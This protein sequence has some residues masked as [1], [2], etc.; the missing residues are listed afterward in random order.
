M[1]TLIA[2][3]LL[4]GFFISTADAQVVQTKS[5]Q[6]EGV[7]LESGIHL[8][9]GIPFAAPPVGDLRWRPP[10]PVAPWDGVRPAKEWG[11][12][13]MQ[14]N[15]FGDMMS[16]SESI[17]E[18]CLYLNVWTPNPSPDAKLPVLVY[19][20]GGGFIAGDGAE[21]RYAGESMAKQGIVA[22]TFNYRLGVFGFFAH[23]ELSAESPHGASGN[24][25]YLD[26][27]AALQWVRDNI[28]AF[29]G[30]PNRITIAGESAG[31]ISVS[32]HM[33][34]PLSKHL[35]QGAIGES[36]SILGALPPVPLE[37]AEQNGVRFASDVGATTLEALRA[38]PADKLL[39]LAAGRGIMGF[40]ST[41]DGYFFEEPPVK[42]FAEGRQAKV[43]L[44]LGWNSE[45]MNAMMVL[46]PNPPTPENWEA[47][48]QRLYGEHAPR[49]LELYKASTEDE[50]LQAATD[51]AGDRFISFS[52]WKWF[53]L[54]RKTGNAPVYRYY[55]TR[56]RPPMRPEVGNATPG[57][58]GG[59]QR[60]EDA[61]AFR[62]P[63]ARGAVHS[64]EIEYAM[65][66][67]ATNPV[68]AW[69]EDDYKVS[70]TMLG[71]FANFVKTGNPNGPGL[72][73]WPA[74]SRDPGARSQIM[75]IDVTS[76][77]E[78]EPYPDRYEF[79]DQLAE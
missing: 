14:T 38:L 23:P 4:M 30:D 20:Y 74:A 68:Y 7:T 54:H 15:V 39:E 31:S 26:Q 6:L 9:K 71:F 55:F 47:A 27:V 5:G 49:I 18:D 66:T 29:G 63:P 70:D 48:V 25:G 72:P 36:G 53:D 42:T 67:L 51:L 77:A 1:K 45:E 60:E 61:P 24:Y 65:G 41:V 21:P 3:L 59:I 32:A 10:Q 73:E 12:R 37:E 11:A 19:I 8:F 28:E 13:C 57:L 69:T 44:L 50:I 40:S 34:S 22:V 46:G 76:A 43:S 52:T 79:L 64:A 75:R 62:M 17:S 33:V 56:P 78:P 35:F 2:T 58:A 16:L